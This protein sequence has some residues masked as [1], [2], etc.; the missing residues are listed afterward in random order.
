MFGESGRGRATELAIPGVYP[1]RAGSDVKK[2]RRKEHVES[3]RLKQKEGE[4]GSGVNM[5]EVTAANFQLLYPQIKEEIAKCDFVAIDTELTGLHTNSSPA[6][7]LSLFDSPE[8]RYGKLRPSVTRFTVSQIG[9][10][11]FTQESNSTNGFFALC[12]NFYLFP[13]S[14]GPLDAEFTFQSSSCSFLAKYGFDFKKFFREGI[15]YLNVEQESRL[16][17]LLAAGTWS[18]SNSALKD[19]LKMTITE[20]SEWLVRAQEG[21][22]LMLSGLPGLQV[23]EIQLMLRRG[24]SNIWTEIEDQDKVVIQ[25]VSYSKR[26]QLENS[27]TDVCRVDRVLEAALGFTLVFRELVGANKPLIGHNMLLD[28]MYIHD[29][30]YRSLPESFAD[31]KTNIHKLFPSVFDTKHISKRMR[32]EFQSL[33]IPNLF[34]LHSVLESRL[35]D[36]AQHGPS[37]HHISGCEK[38]AENDCPHEAAFDAFI[39][40]AVLLQLAQLL[41]INQGSVFEPRIPLIGEYLAAVEPHKNNVNLI[42]ARVSFMS[43][44]GDDPQAERPPILLVKVRRGWSSSPAEIAREFATFCSLDV[45][46]ESPRHYLLATN[47]WKG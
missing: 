20:V 16:Q 41:L 27:V 14:F 40:G 13:P 44:S 22:S 31:F 42:R 21:D 37:L 2:A 39:C 34:A 4:L 18:L 6:G 26:T 19:M 10:S 11:L 9:L 47:E 28:L 36:L 1:F 17:V 15:P 3:Q 7:Q 43:L 45:R 12:Y 38:Y 35:V 8:E 32:Q 29:K 25:K 33:Q 24:I 46:K 5:C 23:F 30:F